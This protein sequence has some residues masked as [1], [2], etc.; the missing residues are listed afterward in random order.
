MK[1]LDWLKAA[2][3]LSVVVFL[4]TGSYLFLVTA[5]SEKQLISQAS[6]VF[7]HANS[8]LD[9]VTTSLANLDQ[10]VAS[11]SRTADTISDGAKK[12]FA[13]VTHPCIPGPCGTLYDVAETL[14]TVR[15]TFGQIEV[16]ANHEDKN[17]TTLDTQEQQLFQ[18]THQALA[19]LVPLQNDIDKTIFDAD[20]L[21]T[22]PDLTGTI[23]NF[24]T[25]SYNFGQTTGDFQ[26]KF[27][28][29]L[30]PAPC[31]NFKCRLLKGYTFV[32]EASSLLEPAYYGYG[33][34]KGTP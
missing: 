3:L 12:T 29:F 30:F 23:H 20:R 15:G 21:I 2:A 1:F 28:E 13:I 22:S 19:G 9:Q 32:K 24:D 16:A 33:L 25:I 34:L 26:I 17:L 7:N 27:H 18:D 8:V 4:G 11:V 6:S 14:H 5:Q 31:T 10:T